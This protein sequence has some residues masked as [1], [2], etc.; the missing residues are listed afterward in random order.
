MIEIVATG[1]SSHLGLGEHE[2]RGPCGSGIQISEQELLPSGYLWSLVLV[3]LRHI[4]EKR[5]YLANVSTS[6]GAL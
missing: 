2:V 1:S 3:E 5:C 4:S 6:E